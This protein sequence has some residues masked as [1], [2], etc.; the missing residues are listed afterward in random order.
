[1]SSNNPGPSAPTPRLSRPVALALIGALLLIV[2]ALLAAN[3][4]S[5]Q[6]LRLPLR[7]T[8]RIALALFVVAFAAPGVP[9][10]RSWQPTAALAFAG[11]HFIHLGLIVARAGVGHRLAILE[12][13]LG[14]IAYAAV[15]FI[16]W[17]AWKSGAQGPLRS[18]MP[19][20]DSA[21]YWVVWA[22]F[23]EMYWGAIRAPFSSVDWTYPVLLGEL[24]LAAALRLGGPYL[25]RRGTSGAAGG[26]S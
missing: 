6:E 7:V 25:F 22:T 16:G 20:A 24:A 18:W 1:M 17:R 5:W 26:P 11:S 8:A 10:L 23:A 21:A 3:G 9:L 14:I 4:T 2:A 12:D 19:Y 15:A 13:F